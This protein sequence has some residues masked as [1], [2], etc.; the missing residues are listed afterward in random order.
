MSTRQRGFGLIEVILSV[1]I[2][3]SLLI[4]GMVLFRQSSLASNASETS[5]MI[6]GLTSDAR[7]MF[8]I[9]PSFDPTLTTALMIDS[10]SVPAG[11]TDPETDVILIPY[12]GTLEIAPSPHDPVNMMQVSAWFPAS[13]DARALCVRLTTQPIEN[14]AGSLGVGYDVENFCYDEAPGFIATF[15]KDGSRPN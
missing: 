15:S 9:A 14:G 5:R 13:F 10:G 12:Q 8:R 6:V 3:L 4:G 2:T 11:M 1:A 7:A